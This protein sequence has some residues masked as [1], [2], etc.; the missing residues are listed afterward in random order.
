MAMTA[1]TGGT[2]AAIANVALNPIASPTGPAMAIDN[3][4]R[5]RLTKKSRLDTRPNSAGG[6][7]LWSSVPQMTLAAEDNAPTRNN[8]T[9]TGHN[10]VAT[11]MATNGTQLTPHNSNMLLR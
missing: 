3:G 7:R 1:R 11:P 6:T 4:I 9:N 8:A 5:A 10:R 2:N